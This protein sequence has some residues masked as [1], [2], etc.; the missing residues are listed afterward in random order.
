M[1]RLKF[2]ELLEL[3]EA[4]LDAARRLDG[5]RLGELAEQRRQ[6]QE[7]IDPESLRAAGPEDRAELRRLAE[8]LRAVDARTRAVSQN[9]LA[10]V[11]SVLPDAPAPTYGRRGQMRGA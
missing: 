9:V 10:V 6:L 11:A 3:A 7:E 5:A 4:Q 8:R 2:A 1:A